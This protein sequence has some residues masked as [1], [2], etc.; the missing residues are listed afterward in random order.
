MN[1]RKSAALWMR[2]FLLLL[3]LVVLT[4]FAMPLWA[5]E[6]QD[7]P[8]DFRLHEPRIFVGGHMGMSFPRAGSDLFSMVTRELTL[9]KGDFR[10]FI[11]GFDFGVMF[12]SRFAGVFS[13]EYGRTSPDSEVR[14]WVDPNGDPIVQTT[15]FSQMP[16]TGTLR[17]YPRKFGETTGSYAWVPTR[18][19][20]YVGGGIGALRYSFRQSG[21]FVDTQTLNI[22]S[23]RLQSKGFVATEHVAA[24]MDFSLSMLILANVEARYSWA[25]ADLSRDFRGFKPIDLAGLRV[26]GGIYFRF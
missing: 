17:F 22:F 23:A 13:F 14:H 7:R 8:P 20:P 4:P 5:E 19:L 24:G 26:I 21:D 6:S 2:L 10:A 12:C 25:E 18:I 9:E 15:R 3:A 1:R 16:I 11:G